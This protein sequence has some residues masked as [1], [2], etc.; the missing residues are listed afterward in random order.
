MKKIIAIISLAVFIT[1]VIVNIQNAQSGYKVAFLNLQQ[2]E[3]LAQGE[4]GNG[5]GIYKK[6]KEETG[7]S[8][9]EMYRKGNQICQEVYIYY[10]VWCG[11][12]G[13]EDCTPETVVQITEN[14]IDI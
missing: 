9:G 2:I 13:E 6:S 14:C 10:D 3:A 11:P 1:A 12:N 5:S 8:Y 7:R 4:G